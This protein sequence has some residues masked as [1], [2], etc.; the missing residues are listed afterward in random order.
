MS[1]TATT[2][3]ATAPIGVRSCARFAA[4]AVR[5]AARMVVARGG[6]FGRSTMA[7]IGTTAPPGD[8]LAP[9]A[10]RFFD[11][12]VASQIEQ[13]TLFGRA[14]SHAQRERGELGECEELVA[15][16]FYDVQRSHART[17]G[18]KKSAN[19]ALERVLERAK[20]LPQQ[21]N[22]LRVIFIKWL[23]GMQRSTTEI[24]DDGKL[25]AKT[26]VE[27]WHARDLQFDRLENCITTR[28]L[29]LPIGS[30]L[31]A[32][33]IEDYGCDVMRKLPSL[34]GSHN[35]NMV[36]Y[37]ALEPGDVVAV[38]R[39]SANEGRSLFFRLVRAHSPQT[40]TD[41]MHVLG[42]A[43]IA[44]Q[45]HAAAFAAAHSASSTVDSMRATT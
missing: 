37:Y 27:W 18:P 6:V 2:T 34:I 22:A 39:S 1:T 16:V 3:A 12:E 41:P 26:T 29:L 28:H 40:W 7:L 4:A 19:A 30:P 8:V 25:P 31:V 13:F 35:D 24:F 38:V 43:R 23:P 5:S 33:L 45:K 11:Q 15:I 20:H 9:I 14:P 10:A 36:Q 32:A 21:A 42:A 17:S 44:E